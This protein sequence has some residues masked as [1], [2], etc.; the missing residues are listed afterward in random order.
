MKPHIRMHR[1]LS[2]YACWHC[3]N[4]EGGAF[5]ESPTDAFET[6]QKYTHKI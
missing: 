5:G 1:T 3:Y 2:G 4:D 6:W